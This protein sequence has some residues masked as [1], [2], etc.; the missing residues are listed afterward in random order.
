MPCH[1]GF[2]DP[3]VIG[4]KGAVSMKRRT[5]IACAS[6]AAVVML[7]GAGGAAAADSGGLAFRGPAV[8]PADQ[9]D[10]PGAVDS[11]EPGDTLDGPGE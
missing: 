1:R 5:K 11:P 4:L 3:I 9:P 2:T 6:A 10:P 7:A 8:V